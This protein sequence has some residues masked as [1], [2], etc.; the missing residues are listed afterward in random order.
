MS[1]RMKQ[2]LTVLVVSVALAASGCA[3]ITG[4]SSGDGCTG[5]QNSGT[6][7]DTGTQNSGT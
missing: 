2:F 1:R 5:T 4:P 3:S 7:S 6:C